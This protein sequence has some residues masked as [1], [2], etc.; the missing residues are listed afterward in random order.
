MV[1][2]D[3]Q[4]GIYFRNKSIRGHLSSRYHVQYFGITTLRGW[5]Y[6]RSTKVMVDPK[7]HTLPDSKVSYKVRLEYQVAAKEAQEAF[8]LDLKARKLKFIYDFQPSKRS[9]KPTS[10]VSVKAAKKPEVA[11][12]A[13]VAAAASTPSDGV[14]TVQIPLDHAP[15][16]V[17]LA[18]SASIEE[19]MSQLP[20]LSNSKHCVCQPPTIE[21]K[22]LSPEV[23]A[24]AR[25]TVLVE[26]NQFYQPSSGS[27]SLEP[28]DNEHAI[29]TPSIS[30]EVVGSN[31]SQ[32]A[33]PRSS[34]SDA[35]S[36][37]KASPQARHFSRPQ[38]KRRP[39]TLATPVSRAVTVTCSE[40]ERPATR[41]N[42][43][44]APPL[45]SKRSHESADLDDHSAPLKKRASSSH[46]DPIRVPVIVDKNG[47][48]PPP[49]QHT[50]ATCPITAAILTPPSSC[51]EE[52]PSVDFEFDHES[53]SSLTS[54]ALLEPHPSS[55]PT[56]KSHSSKNDH[57]EALSLE[58][59]VCSICDQEDT[60]LLHC[61][62][63]CCNSFHL[64]C[65]G[66]V[67]V[68]PFGFVCDDCLYETNQCFVCGK[69][70]NAT[71]MK[72][73]NKPRCSKLY[74]LK[75]IEGNKL[76]SFA[77]RKK[78]SFSCPLHT[79]ARCTSIGRSK[80]THNT[81]IQC[82]KCPLALHKPDCLI[83]GCE[84][85]SP[86]LMICYQHLEI[87]KNVH[88]YTHQNL[89]TCLECGELGDLYCCDSCSAAYH[90]GCLDEEERPGCSEGAEE[91]VWK[92]PSCAVHDLPTYGSIILSKFGIWRWWPGEVI[93]PSA[94]PDNILRRK[95]GKC[96][97][98]M[99]FC[100]SHDF[101]WTYHGRALPYVP[102]S[103]GQAA[104]RK[105]GLKSNDMAYQKALDEAA[106]MSRSK[107]ANAAHQKP[108]KNYYFKIKINKYLVQRPQLSSFASIPCHC[109]P[110]HPCDDS[111][112]CVNRAILF[113]CDPK[114]CPVGK[115]CQNQRFQKSQYPKTSTFYTGGRGWGLKVN[116]D[117]AEGSFV[118][119][120]VG[121]VLD[122]EM[123]RERLRKS[124]ENNT[125]DFYMLTLSNG[126]VI[127]AGQKSNQA[128]FINHSCDPNLEAQKWIV[129][130]ET[131]IG[132]FAR[133]DIRSGTEVTFDYQ[134]D[135]LGNEKKRC[136]CGSENCSGFLGL[137][138]KGPP[139]QDSS[140][141]KPKVAKKK[142]K[143]KK[144]TAKPKNLSTP[145]EDE[146][147]EHSHEDDCFS[148]GDGGKLLM[149]DW[150]GCAKAYHLF[151]IGRK[152]TPAKD[153]V[154][155]C[156]RHF[157]QVCSKTSTVFCSTCP[158]SY[159]S[160]HKAS[161]FTDDSL[162]KGETKLQCLER[163]S[164]DDDSEA[165]IDCS[166]DDQMFTDHDSTFQL[167]GCD[168]TVDSS[169]LDAS[170][171]Q[172]TVSLTR[173]SYLLL[174]REGGES[175]SM[176]DASAHCESSVQQHSTGGA[177]ESHEE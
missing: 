173:P 91:A 102:P 122:T 75:C 20:S 146:E 82:T 164:T 156:P 1:T 121:E 106:E 120:Y 2:Y 11:E 39:S 80:V 109:T 148:C 48:I 9:R 129:R 177:V 72:K 86:S 16:K 50:L 19:K 12:T 123:C 87:A 133:K 32:G 24:A 172:L 69:S 6:A 51:T 79:C 162:Q 111:S 159:C 112:V 119:E 21:K 103:E 5:A 57:G 117:I 68:P 131:K 55:K 29:K 175:S 100:G 94:I 142:V 145:Q 101:C 141:I 168:D 34:N 10:E 118:I 89:N 42:T 137:K 139:A 128:R 33:T 54:A 165:T 73:C 18:A 41:T 92:C 77:E 90:A 105:T 84:I 99:R 59:A 38:R 7:E 96:M 15:Y 76:F 65:L 167:D 143:G 27:H 174:G 107:E 83:A 97:F 47:I 152:M 62:A 17:H 115:L 127:D 25:V 160:K 81:L 93:K 144:R 153:Q 30:M 64:D 13:V 14:L 134:L 61:V 71:N 36:P 114:T 157:C 66:L 158:V 104:W 74:H 155:N 28:L 124:H 35:S 63:Q 49:P 67:K 31:S 170:L 88:L 8:K 169:Q 70:D 163:C 58:L 150:K 98:V 171:E 26:P 78:N 149:C 43:R 113:E 136:L 22:V 44:Y 95:P 60:D 46:F 130:G 132:L 151:C 135:S 154:W 140:Q 161:R 53:S 45:G 52:S 176:E 108:T 23:K 116:Q 110:A 56:K 3:P 85:L 4:L 147:F 166:T 125:T 138:S 126:L 40:A 37:N